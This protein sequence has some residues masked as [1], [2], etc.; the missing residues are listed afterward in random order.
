[1]ESRRQTYSTG[2]MSSAFPKGEGVYDPF[3][4]PFKKTVASLELVKVI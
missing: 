2:T 3:R 4:N 1:M